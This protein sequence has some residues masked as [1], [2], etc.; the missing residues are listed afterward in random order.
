MCLFTPSVL[1]SAA[2]CDGH[3]EYAAYRTRGGNS[4]APKDIRIDDTTLSLTTPL[5]RKHINPLGKYHFDLERIAKPQI[6]RPAKR[7]KPLTE[8]FGQMWPLLVH[9][10]HRRICSKT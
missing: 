4:F 6:R 8:V 3:L 10:R 5:L 2:Q 9:G 1:I 7:L